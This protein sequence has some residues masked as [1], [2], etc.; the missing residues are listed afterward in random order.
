[1]SA[2]DSQPGV[3]E[4]VP[5]VR[6]TDSLQAMDSAARTTRGASATL[7]PVLPCQQGKVWLE[8][9]VLDNSGQ[10][11]AQADCTLK[12]P[13]GDGLTQKTDDKG[14]VKFEGI[15]ADPE[16]FTVRVEASDSTEG[17]YAISV[18]PRTRSAVAP[19]QADDPEQEDRYFEPPWERDSLIWSE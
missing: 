6:A 15:S 1:M 4:D 13:Q 11:V 16:T 17:A 2:W 19:T 3:Y 5:P 12:I 10:P 18:V 14:Y 8:L 9:T 7:E